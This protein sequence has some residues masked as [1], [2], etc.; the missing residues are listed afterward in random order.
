MRFSF[1]LWF[2]AVFAVRPSL[3]GTAQLQCDTPAV[4]RSPG[5][6]GGG[7]GEGEGRGGG[8]GEGEG[9]LLSALL[10]P[11]SNCSL[12]SNSSHR[13]RWEAARHPILH[14]MPS[15]SLYTTICITAAHPIHQTPAHRLHLSE[16]TASTT[17][18]N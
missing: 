9:G 1:N 11:L 14:R 2:A 5:Q 8:A 15:I 10:S 12:E 18:L 16:I 17:G 6:A 13:G 4:L 3:A 7:G